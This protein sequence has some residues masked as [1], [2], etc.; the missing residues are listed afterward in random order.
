MDGLNATLTALGSSMNA[1][2]K[3][4]VYLTN[5]EEW[6]EMNTVYSTYFGAAPPARTAFEVAALVGTS[7]I[8]VS[9]VA[10]YVPENDLIAS[11]MLLLKPGD[12]PC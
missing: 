2:V 4:T 8:E 7:R 3:T 9:N 1:V 5:I 10:C 11:F 12:E 6:A